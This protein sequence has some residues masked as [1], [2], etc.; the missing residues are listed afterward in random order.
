MSVVAIIRAYKWL[1]LGILKLLSDFIPNALIYYGDNWLGVIFHLPGEP[2]KKISEKE[3]KQI[4]A[5]CGYNSV[6]HFKIN[7]LSVFPRVVNTLMLAWGEGYVDE[8]WE[9]VNG[10]EET[11]ELGYRIYDKNIKLVSR[12]FES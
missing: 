3:E 6:F 1:E 11:T 7:H 10:Q 4:L 5:K 2:S 9:A 8:D 12:T